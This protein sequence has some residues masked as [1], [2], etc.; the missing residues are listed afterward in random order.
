M[1]AF[2]YCV[3]ISGTSW[4]TSRQRRLHTKSI[5]YTTSP[6]LVELYVQNPHG[7][8]AREL[9]AR[10]CIHKSAF[11]KRGSVN[12]R[13]APKPAE[14]LRCRELTRCAR[15]GLMRCSKTRSVDSVCRDD[16]CSLAH[17]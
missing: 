1:Y 5:F 15:T 4:P 2:T 7:Q 3:G 14:V 16:A 13:F 11:Y 10:A 9:F 6:P 12:V 17:V 8:R